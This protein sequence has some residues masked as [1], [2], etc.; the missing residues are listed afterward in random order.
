MIR[1]AIS[2]IILNG[3][4]YSANRPV[5]VALAFPGKEI[6]ITITDEGIGIPAK[7]LPHVFDPFFRASNTSNFKGHGIGLPL[8]ATIL[9]QHNGSIVVHSTEDVGTQVHITLPIAKTLS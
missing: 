3:F 5:A 8:T 2:N 7:D 9:R 1:L 6:Q 4:K